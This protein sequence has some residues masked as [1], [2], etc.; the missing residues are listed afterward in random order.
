MGIDKEQLTRIAADVQKWVKDQREI[1]RVYFYG[2]RIWGQ[3]RPDSDLDIFIVASSGAM[4]MC[5]NDW[6]AQLTKLIALTPHLNDYQTADK[7]LINKIKS[8]G[9]LVFSRYGDD[10]DFQF[11]DQCEEIDVNKK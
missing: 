10:T 11:E 8:N 2:S 4:I 7:C 9:F 5:D 3:P 6:T 1:T